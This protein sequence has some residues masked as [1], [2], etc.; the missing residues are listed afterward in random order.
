MLDAKSRGQLKLSRLDARERLGRRISEITEGLT[1]LLGSIYARIDYPDEDLGDYT[2]EEI[3]DELSTLIEKAERL[4]STYRTGRTVRE[5]VTTAIAGKPN[6]GKSTLY[7]IL[8]GT[9][10]AIVTDVAGT[11]RDVLESTVSLGDVMLRLF[12]TAGIRDGGDLVEKIGIERSKR[13]VQD[14]ELILALFDSS[15]PYDSEDEE[16][17]SMLEDAQG[18]KI[19]VITKCDLSPDDEKIRRIQKRIPTLVKIS[20]KDETDAIE[21]LT[22]VITRLF[23]DEKI[24][25]GNDAVISSEM[26]YSALVNARDAMLAAK[27]SLDAGLPQDLASTE[28]EDALRSVSMLDGKEVSELIVSDIF[29]RFCVGK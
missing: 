24:S 4:I 3:S 11:T 13:R 8:T 14:S 17:I 12:D 19:A 10:G 27:S 22:T 5:G 16:L 20:E 2:Q 6:A 25:I 28:M 21:K 23:T 9:D 29:S 18:E 7:N 26:H 15:V 1:T